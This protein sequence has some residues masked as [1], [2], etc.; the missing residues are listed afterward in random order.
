MTRSPCTACAAVG[1]WA[2][3]WLCRVQLDGQEVEFVEID[4]VEG[5]VVAPPGP[6]VVAIVW[7]APPSEDIVQ[8]VI[9]DGEVHHS[10]YAI[11]VDRS[12]RSLSTRVKNLRGR[13]GWPLRLMVPK[14]SM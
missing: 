9:E 6:G 5:E 7:G 10:R 3:L 12:S 8:C 4:E 14:Q 1:D 13:L 2:D 11:L